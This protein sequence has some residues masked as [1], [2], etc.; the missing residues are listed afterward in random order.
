VAGREDGGDALA[1]GAGQVLNGSFRWAAP[2]S[3]GRDMDS[4]ASPLHPLREGA[5]TLEGVSVDLPAGKLTCIYGP[6]GCGL[7]SFLLPP[8]SSS[9]SSSSYLP[10]FL[11]F[12]LLLIFLLLYL[13]GHTFAKSPPILVGKSSL[14]S[15]LLGDLH[16]LSGSARLR[17]KVA[18][19][20]QKAWV[21]N[22]SLRDNVLFGSPFDPLRCVCHT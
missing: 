4:V 3:Y 9:S 19:V 6:T 22:A 16:C 7:Y 8:P 11:S 14:L 17:G 10:I 12:F 15:A 1:I 2:P 13:S 20:P 5:M 18:L 21:Q